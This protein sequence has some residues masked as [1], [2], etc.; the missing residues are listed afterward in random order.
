M[1][2]ITNNFDRAAGS[3][4]D[5]Y[6]VRRGIEVFF[7]EIKQTLQ[8]ADFM[9][10]SGNAVKRRIRTAFLAS[11][12]RCCWTASDPARMRAAPEQAFLPGFAPE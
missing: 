11:V 10:Y 8:L 2:F 7:K 3:V 1:G 4:R 9:G 5:L 6:K 12:L